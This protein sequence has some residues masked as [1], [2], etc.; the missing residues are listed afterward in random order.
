MPP[1]T[2]DR[3]AS[4]GPPTP[5]PARSPPPGQPTA[6]PAGRTCSGA[7]PRCSAPAWPACPWVRPLG[8]PAALPCCSVL[9][10][11][12]LTW[13]RQGRPSPSLQGM[14]SPT[15]QSL[16]MQPAPTSAAAGATRIRSCPPIPRPLFSSP[17]CCSRRRHLRLLGQ[18][19]RG[20]VRA[21]GG[22]RRLVPLCPQPR[23]EGQR[24][25]GASAVAA[26]GRAGG[27]ARTWRRAGCCP[28]RMP[29]PRICRPTRSP[30]PQE[31]YRWEGVAASA[32]AAMAARYRLL[33]LFYTLLQVRRAVGLLGR[34][35]C[36][37]MA[38]CREAPC[39]AKSSARCGRAPAQSAAARAARPPCCGSRLL[40][41]L[42][43]P[44]RRNPAPPPQNASETGHPVLRPLFMSFP[45]DALTYPNSRWV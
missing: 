17:A 3:P 44:C 35:G 38:P 45:R 25:A 36:S 33:P 41:H 15:H 4:A 22:A 8:L 32:R 29:P 23:A 5:A 13:Q 19:H 14:R 27:H 18:R 24:A 7:S 2:R 34:P 1:A 39:I 30:P 16:H 40:T 10:L 21:L 12:L 26:G 6:T 43:A 9:L 42:P 28:C 11:L 37:V 20:A 31:F